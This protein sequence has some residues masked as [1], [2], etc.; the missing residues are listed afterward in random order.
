M[1]DRP[2]T[3][4]WVLHRAPQLVA[5]A[6]GP[7]SDLAPPASP[8]APRPGPVITVSAERLSCRSD[9]VV[10][11]AISNPDGVP[12]YWDCPL[13]GLQYYRDG[14]RTASWFSYSSAGGERSYVP[15]VA[16]ESRVYSHR[17][18]NGLFPRP[19]WYRF[20]FM[21]YRAPSSHAPWAEVSRVSAPF[22]VG[23]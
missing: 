6:R 18:T 1:D 23:P 4:C 17:L 21:L 8:A 10:Q 15:L 16:G 14:W 9:D 3:P 13:A 20:H 5:V 22:F 19:G 7:G 2:P 11:Y 12:I